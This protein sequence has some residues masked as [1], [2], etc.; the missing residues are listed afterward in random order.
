MD[1]S[2][3]L[4]LMVVYASIDSLNACAISTT[5]V[6]ALYSSTLGFRGARRLALPAFFI[7]GVYCGYVLVGLALSSIL[8]YFR[9]LLALVL[10]LALAL[11]V[12]D[13]REALKSETAACRVGECLPAW[14]QR[15]SGLWLLGGALV[16]GVLVS[17]SFML[18][19]AAPY[20][21]FLGLLSSHVA[22]WTVR[23]LFVV[24]YCAIIV[25]PLIIAAFIPTL[26]AEHLSLNLRTVLLARALLL[27][28]VILIGSYY[29]VFYNPPF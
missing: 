2:H 5:A 23:A 13:L 17:W 14:V 21:I 15:L 16:Y 28:L 11:L 18:C 9:I 26:L 12:L 7:L 20:L 25:S 27:A 8:A 3:L 1:L 4:V 29:L 22:S 6:L 19:S 24:I 10:A